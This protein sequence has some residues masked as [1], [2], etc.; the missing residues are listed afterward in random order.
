MTYLHKSSALSEICLV[1][2]PRRGLAGLRPTR[3]N[4]NNKDLIPL[5]SNS[6]KVK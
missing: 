3:N 6:T 5:L 1:I 2:A 4:V